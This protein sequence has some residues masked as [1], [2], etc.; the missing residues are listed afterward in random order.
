M[1]HPCIYCGSECYCNGDID[2]IIVS[3]TPKQCEGC[4][5]QDDIGIDDLDEGW[6]EDDE[7]WEGPSEKQKYTEDGGIIDPDD[8]NTIHYPSIKQ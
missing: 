7:E 6:F 8:P 5:C 2:D 1:A 4:G 3:K